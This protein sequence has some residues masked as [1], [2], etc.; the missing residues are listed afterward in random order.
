MTATMVEVEVVDEDVESL[1]MSQQLSDQDSLP[2]HPFA[3]DIAQLL[4]QK[5]PN[6][7]PGSSHIPRD[8]S[9]SSFTMIATADELRNAVSAL[10]LQTKGCARIAVDMEAHAQHTYCGMSCLIQI[11][12][13][14]PLSYTVS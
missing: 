8:I 11:S 10:T 1:S 3:S 2:V 9:E 5:V 12:T 6:L 7:E 4:D 13:G 14:I